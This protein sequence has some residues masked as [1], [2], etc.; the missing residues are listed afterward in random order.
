MTRQYAALKLLEH[1]PLML[2]EFVAIT[3]WPYQST[4]KVLAEL[5]DIGAI[6]RE[7]W[8]RYSL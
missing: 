3:G 1:G 6:K 5:I 4:Y 8:G 2:A 7:R